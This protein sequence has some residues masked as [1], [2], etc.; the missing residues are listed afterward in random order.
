MSLTV[1]QKTY[2]LRKMK[3]RFEQMDIDKNG[4]LSVEDYQELARHLIK[5]GKLSGEDEQK[6][7]KAMQD[8]YTI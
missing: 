3:T 2:L 5:Y 7:H 4:Y 1:K 6:I 8:V